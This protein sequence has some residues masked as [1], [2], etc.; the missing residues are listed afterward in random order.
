[1]TLQRALSEHHLADFGRLPTHETDG[2]GDGTLVL[3]G[4]DDPGFWDHVI[5]E[6]EYL[7]GARDPLDRWSTRVI[8][9]IANEVGGRPL[10][11]FGTPA[12]PFISWAL[13]SGRAWQSPVM[14]LVHDVA[15]L[16]V[17]YRG[18]VLLP[19][20]S[21][22]AN[23]TAS[24]CEACADKPCLTAC[25]VNAMSS[26]NYNLDACHAWLDQPGG[27]DCLSRGCAAR[28]SCPISKNYG[29]SEKQSAFHMGYFHK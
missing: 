17:S 18:A 1:M 26:Q 2:L 21:E 6:P 19:E 28:R 23:A 27:Q 11:P 7:D 16:M 22:I 8:T 20:H 29:R 24:P 14:I 5:T 25:P 12:R 13:R 15:G 3:L 10:F 9:E 4:P